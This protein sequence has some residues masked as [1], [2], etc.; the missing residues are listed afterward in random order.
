MSGWI[1]PILIILNLLLLPYFVLILATA[2][3]ALFSA[4]RRTTTTLPR[5]RFLV[6]IPAHDEEMGIAATVRSCLGLDYPPELF[7]VVVIADN[8]SDNTALVA[9]REGA[10]VVQRD[11]RAR[12]SK[13]YAIEYL[14]QQLQ[15][16][17]RFDS[18][19]ALVVI[20]ADST[21]SPG[22][23][24]AFADLLESGHDWIQCLYTVSNP[25]ASWRTRLMTY[26][27]SLFNGVTPLG[28]YKL[29]LGAGFRGNG[30]CLSTKGLRRVPWESKGLVED[31]EYSW[32][33]RLAGE[34]I[35]FL[36]DVE[37]RGVMLS[38][39][40]SAA[41]S[42]RQRWEF[43][44]RDIRRRVIGP[45]LRSSR[46]HGIEKFVCFLE[47]TMPATVTVLAAYLC[48]L[49]ANLVTLFAVEL[50]ASSA[51]SVI[52]MFS[53]GLS[54][55]ALLLHT[56]SPFLVFRLPWDYLLI[57]LY[58]PFY[59]IW[60]LLVSLRGRPSR[61]IRTFRENPAHGT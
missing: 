53:S 40:G 5:S 33:V 17:G 34:K 10:T 26:A 56:L 43:G 29:G 45:L 1:I 3:A 15:R 21:A 2:M 39:G 30:M 38:Q 42:Q 50:P 35:A 12:K 7:E 24:S 48:L 36:P 49:I 32:T 59:A 60:K 47:V 55:L 25:R 46:L 9:R 37:V 23:L 58:L 57:F 14:I 11:D 51:I 61:W 18:L 4:R 22:L 20:D 19:D 16:S 31:M 44:R 13:G 8:C 27:F 41:A 52:L 28:L 6:V 54:T